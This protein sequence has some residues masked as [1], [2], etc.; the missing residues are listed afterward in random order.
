MNR[1]AIS[2]LMFE[3]DRYREE[4]DH[5]DELDAMVKAAT[6]GNRDAVGAIAIA[7]GPMLL[8]EASAV[9]GEEW[10]HEAGD[11]LQELTEAL[12]CREL[13]FH[14]RRGRA[15]RFLRGVSCSIARRIK[16]RREKARELGV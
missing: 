5:L 6:L 11:V 10:E 14:P 13:R 9:L 16:R 15:L 1:K 7:F 3:L 12:L 2:D 8:D 4:L